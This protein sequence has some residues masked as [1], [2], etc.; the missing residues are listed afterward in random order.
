MGNLPNMESDDIF[1]K[2]GQR[3]FR[4]APPTNCL[5]QIY[6]IALMY[7]Y[8]RPTS[9]KLLLVIHINNYINYNVQSY[10]NKLNKV[11]KHE[12]QRKNRRIKYGNQRELFIL[13]MEEK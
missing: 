5:Y 9:K 12:N 2:E 7:S 4:L 3:L 11:K 10:A 13:N 6:E 8:T 1:V